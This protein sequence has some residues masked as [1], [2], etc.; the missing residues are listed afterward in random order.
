[1]HPPLITRKEREELFQSTFVL[2]CLHCSAHRSPDG[3]DCFESV[4]DVSVISGWFHG[5]PVSTLRRDNYVDWL[6]WAFFS[7]DRE[8]R[9]EIF[10]E[11]EDEID[12]YVTKLEKIV[13]HKIE[14]GHNPAVKSL[15]VCRMYTQ[16]QT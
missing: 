5:A 12:G 6:F 16:R 10:D 11:W 3:A 4:D 15:R 2:P 7:T 13:G 14:P 9:Q 8:H 1:V